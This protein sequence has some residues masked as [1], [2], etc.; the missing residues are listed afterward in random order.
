MNVD[1]WDGTGTLPKLYAKAATGAIT[2]WLCW[3]DGDTVW[4]EWGQMD[5][6]TQNASFKCKPKNT[7]RANATTAQQQ[8]IKE[9]IAK[10][11]KQ[12]KKKYF[13]SPE[14]AEGTLNLKPMLAKSFNDHKSKV[15]YP[16]DTQPKFDGVRCIA[17]RKDGKVFL[18]SRGGD[19]YTVPHISEALEKCL[20]SNVVLDGELY[21]HGESLQ[22]ILSWVKRLQDDTARLT[23]CV[24]DITDLQDQSECWEVRRNSL[25]TWF[26]ANI[27]S[28]SHIIHVQSLDCRDEVAVKQAHD[29]Y[30]QQ[31]YE[32]AII[33]LREH[34]YRFGYRSPGLLKLKSFQDSE[35]VIIGWTRGKG[36]FTNVP[37]F[38]CATAEG[39]EF[40][41][42]PKGTEQQRLEMLQ[43]ANNLVGKQLT[44]RYFD[45][46]DDRV[47]HFPVGIA[48]REPGT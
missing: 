30:V 40:D 10:W 25:E 24:Y 12:V 17:Y 44:V 1:E 46:T 15:N 14:E 8:A 18:Q 45:W 2:E 13:L 39:R 47:P 9:A 5:G 34:P 4:V 33:R 22:T 36:K 28:S 38:K 11:K 6:A 31:G 29:W 19:P 16:V 42:A 48:I 7:G 27:S 43:N 20:L 26:Q 35:F 23:Y 32:G 3:V 37:I 41:V 21:V